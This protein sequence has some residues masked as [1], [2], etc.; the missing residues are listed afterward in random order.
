MRIGW[1]LFGKLCVETFAD[2]YIFFF[3]VVCRSHREHVS[4]VRR[5]Q[6]LNYTISMYIVTENIYKLCLAIIKK[7]QGIDGNL[8]GRL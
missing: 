3:F 6:E 4:F 7:K 2:V 8:F 1:F 5:S